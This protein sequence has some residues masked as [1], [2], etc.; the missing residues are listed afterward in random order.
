MQCWRILA[1]S[2]SCFS[3]GVP[4]F[5]V[6]RAASEK[7][8]LATASDAVVSKQEIRIP[9]AAAGPTGLQGMLLMPS[10]PDKHPLVLM[11]HATLKFASENREMGPGGL[12][13]EALWFAR[14]GWAVAII[15]R[16]GYGAS[17]GR[18]DE[19]H[20][21]CG[22]A[23]LEAWGDWDASDLRAAYEYLAVR[24][25]IDSSRVIAVGD[26]SGGVAVVSFGL[27]APPGLKAVI[28][29]SGLWPTI[30]MSP[31]ACKN[32]TASS[33]GRLDQDTHVPM[34]WI[35]AKN[36][37][38]MKPKA[39]V[40]VHDAFIA[41]GGSAELATVERSVDDGQ[42]IFGD[43]PELWGPIVEQFLAAHD[44]PSTPLYPDP[45]STDNRLKLPAGFSDAAQKAFSRFQTLGPHKAFAIGPIGEWAYSSGKLTLKLAEQDALGRCRSGQ[46]VIFA[47]DAE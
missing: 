19:Y 35:Y 8:P 18:W 39:V 25:D 30:L 27:H 22:E 31:G 1:L 38:L 15:M 12:Q 16:R 10:T 32:H 37:H 3:M 45:A 47:K 13:P 7:I 21:R 14:R 20:F 4:T 11:T 36:D 23:D 42:S 40:K 2:V 43:S 44:L 46:C 17:G 33:F 41:A 5:F 26:S 34:Q 24:P 6:A 28:S 9:M 29:F